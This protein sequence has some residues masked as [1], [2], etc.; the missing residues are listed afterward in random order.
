MQVCEGYIENGQF[1]P[2]NFPLHNIGRQRAILTILNEPP[3]IQSKPS[4]NQ[5]MKEA[6]R[7]QRFTTRTLECQNDFEIADRKVS[8]QW[9]W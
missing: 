9:D 7:D 6:A 2:I 8:E 1:H 5:F 4:Y 3:S